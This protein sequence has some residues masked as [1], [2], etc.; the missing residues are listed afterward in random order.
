M[1]LGFFRCYE[2]SR[3]STFPTIS[4]YR[5][6]FFGAACSD[7]WRIGFVTFEKLAQDS[8]M[9]PRHHL[10]VMRLCSETLKSGQ[11]LIPWMTIN[12]M[13]RL[14]ERILCARYI[15][16]RANGLPY[17]CLYIRTIC[18]AIT[19]G[20]SISGGADQS[21]LDIDS[22][23]GALTFKSA[24]NYAS[25]TDDGGNNVYDIQIAATDGGG[26]TAYTSLA[27]QVLEV[28]NRIRGRWR[29]H[30]ELSDRFWQT[31]LWV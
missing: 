27:V 26:E 30:V 6:L 10:A 14:F 16:W 5:S 17:W 21:L 20:Y 12:R 22:S 18:Y 2:L 23:T 31:V 3:V 11:P 7:C 15:P 1:T 4:E 29:E 24:P 9:P 8:T 28:S 13:T 19:V 25:P